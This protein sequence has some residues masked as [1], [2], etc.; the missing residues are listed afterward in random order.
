MVH[1]TSPLRWLTRATHDLRGAKNNLN[2][3]PE[4]LSDLICYES[5]QAFEKALKALILHH[6]QPTP[7]THDLVE[8]LGEAEK[9]DSMLD[10]F[11]QSAVIL[12]RYAVHARYPDDLVDYSYDGEQA[13]AAYAMASAVVTYASKVVKAN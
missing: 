6:G 13:E 8:L 9:A 12:A 11:R 3:D 1:S 10:V 4:E 7:R 5:Q 2:D